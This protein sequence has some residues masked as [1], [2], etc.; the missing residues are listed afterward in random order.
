MERAKQGCSTT[1]SVL[2]QGIDFIS[3]ANDTAPSSSGTELTLEKNIRFSLMPSK[4]LAMRLTHH[5]SRGPTTAM[6]FK[7]ASCQEPLQPPTSAQTRSQ[8]AAASI[9]IVWKHVCIVDPRVIQSDMAST[10]V[11]S[12]QPCAARWVL[13]ARHGSRIRCFAFSP[14]SWCMAMA[15]KPP[16]AAR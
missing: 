9:L 13:P 10:T 12:S 3:A 2:V 5:L 14:I 6:T 16:P 4:M 15:C 11:R 7:A 1:Y 8:I